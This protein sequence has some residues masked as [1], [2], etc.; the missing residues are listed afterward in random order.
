M[1][2]KDDKVGWIGDRKTKLA[3]S[4]MNAQTANRAW[5]QPW[6]ADHGEHSGSQNHGCRIVRKKGGDYRTNQIDE[7]EQSPR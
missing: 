4:A 6:P 1:L 5:D 2:V 3:A 7:N